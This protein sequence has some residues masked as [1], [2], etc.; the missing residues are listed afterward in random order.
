MTAAVTA[1]LGQVLGSSTGPLTVFA[2]NNDAFTSI[3]MNYV[4]KLLTPGFD[5][6]LTDLLIS[7]VAKGEYVVADLTNGFSFTTVN[8]LV[9][10]TT[11]NGAQQVELVP[12]SA[13]QGLI[14]PIPIIQADEM[15][16]NGVLHVVADVILPV[17]YFTNPV[18]AL[19]NLPQF[20]IVSSLITAAGLKGAV[21]GLVNQTIVLPNNDAFAALPNAT[22]EYLTSAVNVNVLTKVLEYHVLKQMLPYTQLPVNTT[23]VQTLEGES[24]TVN[25]SM[26]STG[27]NIAFNNIPVVGQGGYFL[28]KDN[29]IY[30]LGGVLIPPSLQGTIPTN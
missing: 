17:W 7:H 18:S 28:T 6:H 4:A 11:F 12:P 3:G 23:E 24:V 15:A 8:N 27:K 14:P 13:A 25:I 2:P 19:T 26:G 29:L 22:V 5:L 10:N 1:G 20:S 30:E 21:M 16:V 9:I